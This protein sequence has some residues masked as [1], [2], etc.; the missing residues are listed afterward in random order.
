MTHAKRGLVAK[1][2]ACGVERFALENFGS[3]LVWNPVLLSKQCRC[4]SD[5]NQFRGFWREDSQWT[6]A[7]CR[8]TAVGSLAQK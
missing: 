4:G 5:G 7:R 6:P 8:K 2:G 1:A 3:M